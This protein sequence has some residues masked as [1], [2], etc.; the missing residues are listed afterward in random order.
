MLLAFLLLSFPPRP[1]LADETPSTRPRIGLCLG[2]GGARGGAHVGVLRV[3]EELRIPVDYIA[4]TSI[5]SIIGG[6]YASGYSPQEL[7]SA[8][9][10]ID[11]TSVFADSPPRGQLLYRRTEE[12]RWPH[13]G[14]EFGVGARAC[15]PAPA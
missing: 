5:G 7:D 10:H 3:L 15:A 1:V 14:F 6:L 4:G 2:G 11:W 13:F 12:D 9:V 8:L